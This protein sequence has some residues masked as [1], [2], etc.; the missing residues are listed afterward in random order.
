MVN[1]LRDDLINQVI[2]V[3]DRLLGLHTLLIVLADLTSQAAEILVTPADELAP[4]ALEAI[5][6][7]LVVFF[8]F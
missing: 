2:D 8:V 1:E 7:S 5:L 4:C 6:Q 3:V